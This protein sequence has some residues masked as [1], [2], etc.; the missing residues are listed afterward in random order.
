MSLIFTVFAVFAV[1]LINEIWWRKR[2]THGEFSRKFVHILVGCFV[3]FWPFYLSWAQIELLSAAFLIVVCISKYLKVFQAIHSVQ[4][5]TWGELFFA[6]SVGAVALLTHNRWVYAASLLQMAL[7]DGLAAIVGVQ[8][9]GSTSYRI[10]NHTKSLVGTL[11]F[12]L[13]SLLV[14]I[15][16]TGAGHLHMP[17]GWLLLSSLVAAILENL[18]ALGLDNLLVPVS[19]ALLLVHH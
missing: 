10:I 18:A 12:F 17:V 3:A 6:V 4:R 8:F 13:V 11:T 2:S 1:L 15:E 19:V 14:L 5:P 9:G 7:A 16:V